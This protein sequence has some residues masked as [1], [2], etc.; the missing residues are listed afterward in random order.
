MNQYDLG[1]RIWSY[2]FVY[3]IGILLY[4]K[5]TKRHGFLQVEFNTILINVPMEGSFD[6]TGFRFKVENDL[7]GIGMTHEEAIYTWR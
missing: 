3:Y 5:D 7:G 1:F 2:W 6:M 4:H